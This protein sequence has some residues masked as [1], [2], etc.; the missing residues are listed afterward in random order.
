MLYT[1][2]FSWKP[3]FHYWHEKRSK[4]NIA[5][6]TLSLGILESLPAGVARIF[7]H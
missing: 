6:R 3:L 2:R 1:G 5:R 4:F 7:D